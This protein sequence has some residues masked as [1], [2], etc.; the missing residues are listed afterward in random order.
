ML[1]KR[2][3]LPPGHATAAGVSPNNPA[4]DGLAMNP[5]T[6]MPGP[7]TSF[8]GLP[9]SRKRSHPETL[10]RTNGVPKANGGGG[11]AGPPLIEP[12]TR[13]PKGW[14]LASLLS[15][16]PWRKLQQNREKLGR[17]PTTA[18]P[19]REPR[20]ASRAVPRGPAVALS[21]EPGHV[22]SMLQPPASP[23]F[24]PRR[25]AA[26]LPGKPA[27]SAIKRWGRY[28]PGTILS[29]AEL[30]KP[31]PPLFAA[32]RDSYTG[33]RACEAT[34]PRIHRPSPSPLPL[35]PVWAERGR[36]EGEGPVRTE[37]LRGSQEE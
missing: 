27:F 5:E 12:P 3:R 24:S 22:G 28:S 11:N 31:S 37:C 36:G 14:L 9:K 20:A 21:Q 1:G 10:P 26:R 34:N 2:C 33:Q 18:Q 7:G 16:S 29:R 6:E 13:Q 4:T 19:G 15:T 30:Q 35:S 17:P 23:L 25:P 32:W 8:V